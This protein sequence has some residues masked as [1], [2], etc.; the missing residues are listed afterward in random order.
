MGA[1][2]YMRATNACTSA[3]VDKGELVLWKREDG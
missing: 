2:I 1:A 3:G